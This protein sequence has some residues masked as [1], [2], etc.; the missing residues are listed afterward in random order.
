MSK[1]LKENEWIS[2][3]FKDLY[4]LANIC[5]ISFYIHLVKLSIYLVC[6]TNWY[7]VSIFP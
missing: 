4:V 2:I 6:P 7:G 1:V 5:L 3:Q